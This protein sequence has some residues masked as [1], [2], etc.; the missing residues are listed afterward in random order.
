MKK[1]Y[2]ILFISLII[3]TIIFLIWFFSK[4]AP[5]EKKEVQLQLNLKRGDIIRVRKTD[6]VDLKVKS[7]GKKIKYSLYL[8]Y[9]IRCLE[10][11]PNGVMI[12]EQ[13]WESAWAK[14]KNVKGEFDWKSGANKKSIPLEAQRYALLVGKTIKV[15]VDSFGKMLTLWNGEVIADA[16]MMEGVDPARD[17]ISVQKL[18]SHQNTLREKLFHTQ[19][20]ILEVMLREYPNNTLFPDQT[21]C[22]I[23]KGYSEWGASP[24]IQLRFNGIRE[25]SACFDILTSLVIRL[26]PSILPPGEKKSTRMKKKGFGKAEIDIVT[27]VITNLE[28]NKDFK[29]WDRGGLRAYYIR[30]TLSDITGNVK[31]ELESEITLFE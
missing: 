19:E 26:D 17:K 10:R 30:N 5:L 11:D 23:E 31:S 29:I 14:G 25:S 15:K 1:R 12:L 3:F 27:G 22:T 18:E 6:T 20:Y 13:T 4:D 2:V 8:E 7:T 24:E 16:M 21:F 9:K 28:I